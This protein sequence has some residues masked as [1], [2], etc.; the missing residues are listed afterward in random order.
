MSSDNTVDRQEAMV[1]ALTSLLSDAL[2][3]NDNELI[4][5]HG[6]Q[7]NIVDGLV[8]GLVRIANALKWLGLGD[9][10][11]PFGAIEAL[12]VEMKESSER[13]AGGLHDIAEAIRDK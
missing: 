2:L 5:K 9:A 7:V 12:C 1:E 13:I 11:T 8:Y 3:S 10:A 6:F 4:D